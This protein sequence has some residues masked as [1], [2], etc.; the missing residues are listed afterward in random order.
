MNQEIHWQRLQ[1]IVEQI[2][3]RGL[4]SLVHEELLEFGRLYRRAASDLSFSQAHGIDPEV[5]RYLNGLVGRAYGHV[6]QDE[7][8]RFSLTLIIN[9][10]TFAFP[11]AVRREWPFLAGSFGA[12]LIAALIAFWAVSDD[13]IYSAALLPEGMLDGIEQVVARHK[14]GGDWMPGVIRPATS[15]VIMTNNV[16]VAFFAFGTGILAGLG[17]LYI[18]VVNG[19]MMGAV[20]AEIGKAD[21]ATAVNFWG[22]VAP[23]GVLELPAIFLAG[24]AGLMM[25]YTLIHPGDYDRKT[26]LKLAGRRAITILLGVI[27]MLVIAGIIEGFYSPTLTPELYKFTFAGIAFGGLIVY[28]FLMPLSKPNSLR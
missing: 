11:A 12:F 6:Y 14:T 17:T 1:S 25:G 13:P 7:S 4:K 28:L 2:E 26:A 5:R 15:S 3:K 8:K 19:L 16:Q 20:A 27:A 10:F 23:H 21:L 24:A 9:F 18:L 22:F